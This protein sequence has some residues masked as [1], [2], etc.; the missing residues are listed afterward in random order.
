MTAVGKFSILMALLG[1]LAACSSHSPYQ[2]ASVQNSVTGPWGHSQSLVY[3]GYKYLE[4]RH[5]RLDDVQKAKH[6]GAVYSALE[7]EYGTV[8]KWFYNDALGGSKAVHG[9]PQGSGF[10]K[11]VYSYVV[12]RDKQKH[13]E[14][15]AC[16]EEGHKG[17]RFIVK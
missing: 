5:Y 8:Y 3:Y 9:Y 1:S 14:E 17:W 4:D 16:K 12:V 6:T 15:T 11:V 2:S 10:C 7:G 13:F